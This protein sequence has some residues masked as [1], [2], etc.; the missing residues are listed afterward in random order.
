MCIVF[1]LLEEE[2]CNVDVANKPL[3][4]SCARFLKIGYNI[5]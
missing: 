3:L 5:F 2:P 1:Y 4:L